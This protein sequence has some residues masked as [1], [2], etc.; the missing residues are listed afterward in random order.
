M[1]TFT[2]MSEEEIQAS[3]L[4]EDGTYDFE[5]VKSTRKMSRSNN[6]MAELQLNVWDKDGRQHL[7]Y[8]YLVFSSI[9]LNIRKVKHFCEAVGLGEQYKQ[10]QIPE[11]LERYCGKAHVI[12]QAGN[13]IPL[14]K[15]NGKPAGSRYPDK[16]A[17][18]DY[19]ASD[20]VE[21]KPAKPAADDL[22]FQD[23][24]PF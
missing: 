10:G 17:V 16:N 15:L 21:P 19:I 13:E 1:Y 18:E 7:V 22:P 20:K 6:P 11:E 12:K 14:E 5:V 9:P 24:I 2:P 3:G 8:D 4:M 23:D